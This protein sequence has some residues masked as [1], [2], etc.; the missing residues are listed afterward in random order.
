M[1]AARAVQ[2]IWNEET[3]PFPR[4]PTVFFHQY[5]S[6]R[7]W[8]PP[9]FTVKNS[10]VPRNKNIVQGPQ[11]ISCNSCNVCCMVIPGYQLFY[12]S[13]AETFLLLSP[14][15]SY[16]CS[17]RHKVVRLICKCSTV[18]VRFIF[19]CSRTIWAISLLIS[20]RDCSRLIMAYP[21]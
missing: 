11:T 14:M 6:F 10:P 8:N 12:S 5:G 15:K 21:G 2:E 1:V 19:S 18:F 17:I 13:Y 20:S 4:L 7:I 3:E 9:D 16:F